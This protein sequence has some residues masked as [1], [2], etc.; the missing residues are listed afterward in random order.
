MGSLLPLVAQ[1][2]LSHHHKLHFIHPNPV[3]F[4]PQAKTI[5]LI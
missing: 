5:D 3:S 2:F 1:S 4:Q